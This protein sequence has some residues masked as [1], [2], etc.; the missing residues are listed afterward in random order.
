[1]GVRVFVLESPDVPVEP[2]MPAA[3]RVLSTAFGDV[4]TAVPVS[5]LGTAWRLASAAVC[6]VTPTPVVGWLVPMP[7]VVVVPAV[8]LA[9]A[10][11]AAL[12]A[13]SAVASKILMVVKVFMMKVSPVG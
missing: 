2:V 4:R 8:P 7:G 5:L 10:I 11:A 13:M 3:L 12:P 1:M 6:G 9:C